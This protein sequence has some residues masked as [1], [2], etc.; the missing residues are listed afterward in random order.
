MPTAALGA[1]RQVGIHG[2]PPTEVT[3]SREGAFTKVG[4]EATCVHARSDG[5]AG[6]VGFDVSRDTRPRGARQT[7]VPRGVAESLTGPRS[8]GRW[9]AG[10]PM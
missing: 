6:M 8:L 5:C 9:E 3:C 1:G 2:E 4:A 7:L 10:V